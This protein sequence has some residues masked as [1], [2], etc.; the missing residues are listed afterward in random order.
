MKTITKILIAIPI[1]ILIIFISFF[2]YL[3]LTTDMS[4]GINVEILNSE[5][6]TY[7]EITEE[8]INMFPHLKKAILLKTHVETPY[9]E[10]NGLYDFLNEHD[11]WNILYQDEYY[12]IL[13]SSF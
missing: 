5:P 10:F 9:E 8:E 7:I 2:I 1:E 11:S 6:E 13:L 12:H 3:Y 4:C